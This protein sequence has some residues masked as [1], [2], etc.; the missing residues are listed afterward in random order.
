M[1][2]LLTRVDHL[3]AVV[4]GDFDDLVASE[5]GA[6]GGVLAALA[7]DVGL[8]GLY[9]DVSVRHCLQVFKVWRGSRGLNRSYFACAC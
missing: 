4:F 1:L 8:V 2:W 6:N 7:N 3:C 9:L 5:I